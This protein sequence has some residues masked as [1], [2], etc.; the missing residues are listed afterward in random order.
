MSPRLIGERQWRP[1]LGPVLGASVIAV[2]GVAFVTTSLHQPEVAVFAPTPMA[3][4]EAGHVLVGPTVYTVDAT[5][6]DHWRRFSFRLG[7]VVDD[8]TPVDWD[9]AFRRF[10]IIANGGAAFLGRGGLIDLGPTPFD[11]IGSVPSAGYQPNEGRSDPRNPAIARWYRYGF[12]SHLLTP[13]PNVWAVRTADERYAKLQILSYYCPGPRPGCFTF[14]YVYQGD[15][16]TVVALPGTGR[17]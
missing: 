11:S 7:A 4:P 14:R 3:P 2:L 13:K 5:D 8:A 16:S 10:Q 12:F 15:G 9:L 17:P 1:W 6:A